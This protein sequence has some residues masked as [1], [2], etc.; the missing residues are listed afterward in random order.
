MG[1]S[2]WEKA[3]GAARQP[4]PGSSPALPVAAALEDASE[5]ARSP[6]LCSCKTSNARSGEAHERFHLLS[7]ILT[8]IQSFKLSYSL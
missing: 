2:K 8:H 4:P 1:F 5:A 3:L 7:G 6:L